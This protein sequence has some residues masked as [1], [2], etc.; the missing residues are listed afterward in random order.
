M[1]ILAHEPDVYP[2]NLFETLEIATDEDKQWYA[3]HTRPRCEKNLARKLSGADIWHCLPMHEHKY[4]SPK[5]RKCVSYLPLFPSYLFL[6]ATEEERYRAMATHNIVRVMDVPDGEQLTFDLR[7]VKRLLET[8]AS[9]RPQAQ[10]QPGA[11]VRV[12][13]GPF[14][15]FEG[16]I[17]KRQSGDVL[18]VVVHYL[19]Q[20]ITIALDDCQVEPL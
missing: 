18:L 4:R 9:L 20:G 16:R 10:L 3:V 12:T 1:P 19:Q 17:I 13:N 6:Y 8:G 11:H 5:G 7:Q 14:L 2:D 15:N